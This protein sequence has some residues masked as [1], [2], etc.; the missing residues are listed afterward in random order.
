MI[1]TIC[2]FVGGAVGGSNTLTIS[3]AFTSFSILTLLN[4][5]LTEI[6]IS[7]PFI[8][9]S[10]TSLQRIQDYLN[11]TKRTDNRKSNWNEAPKRGGDVVDAKIAS[12]PNPDLAKSDTEKKHSL[13]VSEK[14]G[15]SLPC[16]DN[17]FVAAIEGT[18]SWKEDSKPVIDMNDWKVPKQKFTLVLGPVGCGKSTLLK[19]LLGE[20]S[21]D[22]IATRTNYTGVA[23]CS[24]TP[25]LPNETV[26]SIIV[27]QADYDGSWY[28][29]V[30]KACA[31]EPDLEDWPNG[32]DTLAGSMGITMSGGQKHR[33]VRCITFSLC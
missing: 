26:R 5:P 32:D 31:L 33:L 20:L 7:L 28:S 10:T 18:Y 11:G 14:T 25:W 13:S 9:S 12:I 24:Q 17:A 23:F 16:L 3:K 1:L 15:N 30:I 19:C 6:L 29:T 2:V 22:T 4:K 8:A 27:G 21:S